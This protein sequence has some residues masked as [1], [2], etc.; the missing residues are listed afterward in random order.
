MCVSLNATQLHPVPNGKCPRFVLPARRDAER[1]DTMGTKHQRFRIDRDF[2]RALRGTGDYQAYQCDELR[3]FGV[4]VTPAGSASYTYR[5]TKPDGTQGRK[6]IGYYPAM[7]PGDARNAAKRESEIIDHK[8]DTLTVAAVRKVKRT[9]LTRTVR[10]VPTLRRYLED[11]YRAESRTACKTADHGDANAQ[12]ILQSF[13]DF[14]DLPLDQLTAAPLK[15]W[16]SAQISAGLAR[17]TTNKKLTALRGLLTFAVDAEILAAHPMRTVKMLQ[18]PSGKVRYLTRDEADRLYK[19]MVAREN[20]IRAARERTN[21]HRRRRLPVLPDLAQAEFVDPLRPAVLASIMTGLRKGELFNLRWT[22]IDLVHRIVTVRDEHAKSGKQRHIP[23][24]AALYDVF[25]TWKP[26]AHPDS[27]YVFA[28]ESGEP[29]QCMKKSF[30]TVLKAARIESYRWHDMRHT[31]ASWLVQSGVDL[32][33]VREMLGHAS[34]AM[35]MRYAHLAPNN[36]LR[37]VS[38]LQLSG[39]NIAQVAS[40]PRLAA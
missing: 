5:W 29:I 40:I 31:F 12:I 26:L 9:E 3:G 14:L 22:D 10:G 18:E 28:G 24:N 35:T 4:K 1:D 8:G 39:P 33:I 13:P 23:I 21:E 34:L 17:S 20:D 27:V 37:A 25:V 2:M 16:R 36:K 30:A 6:T 15:E 38:A 32:N 7:N 11:T 19:A